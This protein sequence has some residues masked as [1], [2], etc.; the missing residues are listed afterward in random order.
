MSAS[1]STSTNPITKI[2]PFIFKNLQI[3]G[4]EMEFS[5]LL[6]TLLPEKMVDFESLK[7]NGFDVHFNALLGLTNSG[8]ILDNFEKDT[9]YRKDLLHR[10]CVDMQLKGKVKGMT[11]E[12]KVLFKII[13]SSIC[14]RVGGTDIISW[15]HRHL[16]YFLLTEKKVNLGDYFFE[17]ICEAI[18]YRESQRRTTIVHPRL[19]SDLLFQG[20]II[21]NLQK[22]YPEL[23]ASKVLPDVLSASFLTKMHLINSKVVQP[24]QEFEVRL[25]DRLYVDGYPVISEL[26]CEE[27]IQDYLKYLRAEGFT[28]T[29]EMVPKAPV[30]LY[31]P[32]QRKS[33]RKA[34]TQEEQV[35]PDLLTQKKIKVEQA[36]AEQRTKKKHE[37]PAEKVAEESSRAP[38]RKMRLNVDEDDSEETRSDEETLA[39]KLSKKQV[40]VSKGKTP[41]FVFNEAEIGIGYT[42]PLRTIHPEAINISSSD[43]SEELDCSTDEMIRKG[44]ESRDKFTSSDKSQQKDKHVLSDNPISELQK[45]LSPDTLNNH[46]FSHETA[47]PISPPKSNS[48]PTSAEHVSP[49]RVHTCA[50][51]PS[52]VDVVLITNSAPESPQHSTIPYISTTSSDPFG[53]LSNQLYDDLLRLSEIKNRFLV[54]PSDVDVEV[55]AIKAKI[56]NALDLVGKD[57]KAVIGKR[58]LEVVNLM[59]EALARVSLKRLTMFNHEEAENARASAISAREAADDML[60]KMFK[61]CGVDSKLF[62]SLEDQRI[63]SERI[64]QATERIAQAAALLNQEEVLMLG[65]S[66]DGGSSSDK[67]K[68]PLEPGVDHLSV[69]QQAIEKQR[70]DHQVLETKVDKLDSKVDTLNDKF[71]M[72]IALLKKP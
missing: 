72:I 56:C 33:K 59:R 20:G 67:G 22:F 1:T 38:K 25:E 18:F 63:E 39:D 6:L 53:N 5:E 21:K 45:H 44:K 58:D 70:S 7:A 48:P 60:L 14:P 2:P 51:C 8:L 31:N 55:S 10:M 62:K 49:E 69:F 52:E 65:F 16:I 54:C 57:I 42:K 37:A 28:V 17:R 68:A 27:V 61:N 35:K 71:D 66:E 64:A 24:S 41:K 43:N 34:E 9:T 23:V 47:K 13:I 4:N 50:P 32:R 40:H 12:C 30:N 36:A 3:V 26:D 46:P 29:R 15:P 19:L 11:D